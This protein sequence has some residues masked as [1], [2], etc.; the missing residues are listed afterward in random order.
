MATYE[1]RLWK[2]IRYRTDLIEGLDIGRVENM[3][4]QGFP[5]VEGC[6]EGFSFYI[7]LKVVPKRPKTDRGGITV[8]FQPQQPDWLEKRW[9]CGGACYVLIQVGLKHEAKRYLIPG[10]AVW[11]FKDTVIDES[12][13]EE[14]SVCNP[15]DRADVIIKKAR[16]LPPTSLEDSILD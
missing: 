16:R 2:W 5:D 15:K 9:A 8:T 13:L 12:I 7:E 11:H 10:N 1:S 4:G 3:V 6:W 14:L